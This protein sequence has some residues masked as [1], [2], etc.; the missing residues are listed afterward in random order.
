MGEK[1]RLRRSI[2]KWANSSDQYAHDLRKSH[3]D[4]AT[5]SIRDAPDRERVSLRGTLKT[6][7]LRPH[8][9]QYPTVAV[10]AADV[11]IEGVYTGL[12]RGELIEAL[13][14]E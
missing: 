3:A 4:V 7:T 6:V 9:P 8:N 1:S 14:E 12:V 13:Y 11:H 10:P 5:D 2:S